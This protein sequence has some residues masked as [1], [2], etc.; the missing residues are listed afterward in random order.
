MYAYEEYYLEDS[1]CILGEYLDYM[2]VDLGYDIDKAFSMFAYSK[3]GYSFAKG[4][5]TYVAGV[6]GPE[7]AYKLMFELTGNWGDFIEPTMT[8]DRSST[9]WTGWAIARYQWHKNVTF[10]YLI[11]HGLTASRV[12]SMYIFHEADYTKFI[13][14]ADIIVE[15]SLVD[16]ETSLKRIRKYYKLTQRELSEKSG[17]S[18]RMIQLYEQKQSDISKAQI[19]IVK[20]LADALNCKVE[21]LI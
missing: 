21:D 18:L 6:S 10:E 4:N 12:E 3:I 5:P 14:Q 9:Y 20:G 15:K 19:N 17:V 1:E 16:E 8:I 7:L 11:E 2:V 13:E